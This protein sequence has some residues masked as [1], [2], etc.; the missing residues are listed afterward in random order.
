MAEEGRANGGCE[1]GNKTSYNIKSGGALP[2]DR[3]VDIGSGLLSRRAPGC[4][5]RHTPKFFVT[6]C[7]R[8]ENC[9]SL[10]FEF[11]FQDRPIV[12]VVHT[13]VRSSR[14]TRASI[15]AL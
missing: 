15:L 11:G 2:T 5:S 1:N 12:L 13:S 4:M 10:S 8:I 14:T 7:S 9:I 3:H 6:N